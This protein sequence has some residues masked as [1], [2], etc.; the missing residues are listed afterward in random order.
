MQKK[1]K[2]RL[3]NLIF[4]LVCS[5]VSLA[6][7]WLFW[8]DLNKTSVRDDKTQI[9]TILFKRNIAQRKFSDRVVW[10]RLR[11]SSPLYDADTLRIAKE[12]EARIHFKNN[13][14][15][16]I[17][18]NTMLQIFSNKDGSISI[19]LNGGNVSVDTTEVSEDSMPVSIKLDNGSVMNLEAGSKITA[20]KVQNGEDSFQIQSGNAVV[21]NEDGSEESIGSGEAFKI[22]ENG[23]VRKP[24]CVTSVTKDVKVVRFEDEQ[25]ENITIKWTTSAEAQDA[26]V[27]IE[28]SYDKDFSVI[29]KVYETTGSSSVTIESSEKKL[30]WRVYA[31][32]NE[33]EAE[34]GKI[35]VETV[36]NVRP[37]KPVGNPDFEYRKDPPKVTFAWKGNDFADSY[38]FEIARPENQSAPVF[39]K[40]VESESIA[41]EILSEGD[42]VWKVTPHYE[43][44][45]IGWGKSTDPEPLKVV[46]N[47]VLKP[48][49]L[50]IPPENCTLSSVDGTASVNFAWKSEIK[51]SEYKIE[52]SD[53]P[54]FVNIVYSENTAS[55]VVSK[56][57]T[58][59]E[60]GE[61]KYYWRVTRNS[62]EETEESRVSETRSFEIAEYKAQKV[63]LLYPPVNYA[64]DE[65]AVSGLEF[66]WKTAEEESLFQI[67]DSPAFDNV[68]VERK[69]DSNSVSRLNLKP[70]EYYW[71]AGSVKAD[72][73]FSSTGNFTVLAELTAPAL[74]NIVSGSSMIVPS[75][76]IVTLKWDRQP[77][78]D[79]YRVSLKDSLGNE[80]TS[81][82]QTVTD[83]EITVKLPGL[84]KSSYKSF[85]FSVQAVSGKTENRAVR[86]SPEG[87]ISFSA[88]NPENLVLLSPSSAS[89][90]EI[91]GLKALR[92][93]VN[94]VWNEKDAVAEGS[95]SLVIKKLSADGSWHTVKRI[96]NPQKNT[97]VDSL[98]PG[99]YRWTVEAS[100]ANGAVLTP[101]RDAY[102]TISEIPELSVPVLSS[103]VRNFVIGPEYLKQK[104]YI[105]FE[106]QPVKS[107]T[108][109]VFVLYQK[110]PNGGLR[111]ITEQKLSKNSYRFRNLKKLDIASFEWQVTAYTHGKKGVQE[112]KSGTASQI[113]KIDFALPAKVRTI[114]PGTQY[115]E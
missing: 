38:R 72:G 112:M 45:E 13:A 11:Q 109:Y 4:F 68:I 95:S 31:V 14:Y 110:M 17:D 93:K 65:K 42:Y 87:K 70:G 22:T 27:R 105:N 48:V 16:N 51:D 21:R 36:E 32:E 85:D 40:I 2:S 81:K 69:T 59:E 25:P 103:P 46:Q 76:G 99:R 6:F 67:S 28:T 26:P 94:F 100:G 62:S 73:E 111:K 50:S 82:N 23:V 64:L 43:V 102:F 74:T 63:K 77:G 3:V 98:S 86:V 12:A 56:N 41:L 108:D 91:S 115:G 55:T 92:E 24:V 90:A 106:W 89:S 53:S 37:V 107:A 57:F 35:T 101:E 60:L 58:G 30:Y 52:V 49:K 19:S 96:E 20:S 113:F 9:A 10:E 39:E 54:D 66:A 71:R 97:S 34:T 7:L 15:L 18:E 61:G 1:T 29:E 83:S 47:T 5:S 75:S 88:R 79:Y 104:R 44:N 84:E 33:E 80:I 114:D 78:V 8:Q